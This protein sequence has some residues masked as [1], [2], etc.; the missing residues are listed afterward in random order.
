[1]AMPAI[2]PLRSGSLLLAS[3]ALAGAAWAAAPFTVNPNQTATDS[4]TGLVWDQCPLGQSGAA[5]DVGSTATLV[6]GDALQ[7]ATTANSA[8]YKGFT[9]WRVPNKNELQS[10][11]KRDQYIPAIDSQV[12]PN[13]P[14]SGFWTS[15]SAAHTPGHAWLVSFTSGDTTPY[16]KANAYHARLV[17]GGQPFAAFDSLDTAPV[18]TAL[19][20]SG[21]G[22][23]ATTL[24][25]TSSA[26]GIGYWLAVPQG[27]V[28]PTPTQ[29]KAGTSYA[30]AMV[31]AAGSA[32]MA[33]TASTAF[34]ISGLAPSTAYALYLVVEDG[35]H[36]LSALSG[37][38]LFTTLAPPPVV[39]NAPAPAGTGSIQS[40]I[41]GAAPGCGFAAT[42]YQ[43][44]TVVGAPLPPG[45]HFP[46]G[47][48]SFSTTDCSASTT[49]RLT[50][51]YPQ[52]L[53]AGTQYYKFGVEPG[54]AT[55]HWYVYPATISGNQ[56]S[57]DVTDN[58][59]GDDNPA[60]GFIS[61]PGGPG[62]PDT[63][64]GGLTAIPTL[65]AWGLLVLAGLIVTFTKLRTYAALSMPPSGRI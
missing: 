37:P 18:V 7:A 41:A 2:T 1:M 13:T 21:I 5:C 63:A 23:V 49:L 45:I 44:A 59:L 26:A 9:D 46:E 51:T 65:S 32:S 31:A 54:N 39:F 52:A 10:L 19:G 43:A 29:A 16:S 36:S 58:G 42:Q 14:A 24:S 20:L 11:V 6:W 28:A 40:A 57:F 25:A 60:L 4:V 30:G 55:A 8:N 61:D 48:F 56:I 50:I 34:Y 35:T 17:R 22:S 12:F 53:P 3:L 47:L 64:A 15:T 33:A 27:S 62:V 38:V